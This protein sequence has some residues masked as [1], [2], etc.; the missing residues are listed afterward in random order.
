[1]GQRKPQR[2]KQN[3]RLARKSGPW[4]R[5]GA[6]PSFP[7]DP[8]ALIWLYGH[9][10]VAAA[11]A[12][13]ARTRHRLVATRNAARELAPDAQPELLEP[14][15]IDALLPEGAVHQGVALLAGPLEPPE[16]SA[17]LSDRATLLFLD[18]VTDPHN[19]GA[20]LRS[21]AAFGVRGVVTTRRHAPPITG[22]LAKAA[23]GAIEH[24]PYLQIANLA[25]ALAEA[26]AAGF[27]RLGL[28][29]AG[30]PIEPALAQAPGPVALIVG[31]EGAG[32]RE[33]T[34]TVCDRLVRLPTSGPIGTLNVSNA[35]AV[36][37]Y[38]I[39]RRGGRG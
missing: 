16:L 29:E 4:R 30:D 25:D 24:V 28:E 36:A 3:Q 22:V 6:R 13:P 8:E 37:L 17:L 7:T 34:R 18:Q 12:N 39:A 19:V 26:G 5:S 2:T 31:A 32:L 10:A 33:R 27:L 20:I 1:M 14:R 38:A 11:L 35:V 23:S 21:A 9:H 15:A